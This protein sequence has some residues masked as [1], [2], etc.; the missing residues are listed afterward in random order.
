MVEI[1]EKDSL[2]LD[3]KGISVSNFRKIE[4]NTTLLK[5]DQQSGKEN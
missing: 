4:E 3:L 5:K 1:C 2:I